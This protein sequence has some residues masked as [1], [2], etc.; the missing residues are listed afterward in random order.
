MQKLKN[1]LKLNTPAKGTL[2]IMTNNKNLEQ[3]P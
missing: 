3:K 1:N 2:I